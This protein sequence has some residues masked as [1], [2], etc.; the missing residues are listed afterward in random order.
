MG[1]GVMGQWGDGRMGP[2][3]MMQWGDGT[4]GLQMSGPGDC[5][6]NGRWE[7]GGM[8]RWGWGISG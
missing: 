2:W 8:G 1:D 5:G 6:K 4:M 7:D 3:V